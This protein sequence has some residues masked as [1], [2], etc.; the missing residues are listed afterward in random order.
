MK[1]IKRN[2]PKGRSLV[3]TE[4]ESDALLQHLNLDGVTQV[5]QGVQLKPCLL[6][7]SPNVV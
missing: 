2:A 5:A 7:H 6:A 3:F 1:N 4:P